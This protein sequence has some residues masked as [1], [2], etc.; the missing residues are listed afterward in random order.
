MTI[1]PAEDAVLI[2]RAHLDQLEQ[3]VRDGLQSFLAVGLAL[4]EIRE[5]YG[6]RLRGFGTFE[7]YCQEVF[8]FTARHGRR[9]I[10]AATTAR[11]V[12][13]ATGATLK[14]ENMARALAPVAGDPNALRHIKARLEGRGQSFGNAS[15]A[16]VTGILREIHVL[17]RKPF[18][19]KSGP[20]ECP[21]C[22][23]TPRAY[24][25]VDGIW[26]CGS[27][28]EQVYLRASKQPMKGVSR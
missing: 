13:G 23:E 6:Y 17:P 12:A 10:Q 4:I 18:A 20:A 27:C 1:V 11:E 24:R 15:A 16:A 25:C 19:A 7:D 5:S 14:R 8:G 9:M 3:I 22:G 28:G 26:Q 21:H 2:S